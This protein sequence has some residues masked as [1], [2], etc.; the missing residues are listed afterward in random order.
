MH[1]EQSVPVDRPGL[2]SHSWAG[3]RGF[4]MVV[5]TPYRAD[6]GRWAKWVGAGAGGEN[7]MISAEA[8]GEP[9]RAAEN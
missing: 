6:L 9:R 3:L 1:A 4:V 8:G 5:F 2:A 7:R